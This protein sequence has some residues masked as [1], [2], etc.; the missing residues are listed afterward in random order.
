MITLSPKC[1]PFL[2][3]YNLTY[4]IEFNFHL[5][6]LPNAD[7][8][9]TRWR[10][11]HRCNNNNSEARAGHAT[12]EGRARTSKAVGVNVFEAFVFQYS[13]SRPF[14]VPRRQ[15]LPPGRAAVSH[16]IVYLEEDEWPAQ[17]V[18]VGG[19]PVCTVIPVTPTRPCLGSRTM[20][21]DPA[22]EVS[23]QK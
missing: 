12:P 20:M 19:W 2:T 18:G 5:I 14:P 10:S 9:G 17:R 7:N 3:A 23:K 13:L 15:A 1:V 8:N 21:R 16:M 11:I 6:S 22:L 4:R